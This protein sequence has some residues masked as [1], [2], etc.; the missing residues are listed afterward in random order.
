MPAALRD[1]PKLLAGLPKGCWVALSSDEKTV[2]AFAAELMEVLKKAKDKGEPNPIVIRVPE[3][4]NA[5]LL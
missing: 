3:K 2:I 1:F 4:T 5:A